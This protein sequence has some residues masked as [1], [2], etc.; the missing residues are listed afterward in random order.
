M[1]F[2]FGKDEK[3]AAKR[4]VWHSTPYSCSCCGHWFSLWMLPSK[5]L[6]SAKSG[7]RLKM[8]RK[9]SMPTKKAK[10]NVNIDC[11]SLIIGQWEVREFLLSDEWQPWGKLF[12]VFLET[13]TSLNHRHFLVAV[14]AMFKSS[15]LLFCVF[16]LGYFKTLRVSASPIFL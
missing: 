7:K 15:C 11:F 9:I 2:S 14:W 10:A 8:K 12:H 3:Y 13:G 5:F 16:F 6:V 4:S 1:H